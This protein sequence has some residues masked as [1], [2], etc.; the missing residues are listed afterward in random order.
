MWNKVNTVNL[1]YKSR[2]P[3]NVTFMSTCPLYTGHNYMHYSLMEKRDCPLQTVNCY[4]EVPFKA[5]LIVNCS[6][7]LH[8]GSEKKAKDR[9]IV[10]GV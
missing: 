8:R 10:V 7:K 9:T 5:G 2:E 6:G 3:E 4:I 1:V